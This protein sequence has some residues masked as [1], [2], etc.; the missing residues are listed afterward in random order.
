MT[1]SLIE[2]LTSIQV[3]VGTR[4]LVGISAA[5]EPQAV[6]GML[7]VIPFGA[8]PLLTS[9]TPKFDELLPSVVAAIHL[10][11]VIPF[12][13]VPLLTSITPLLAAIQPKTVRLPMP[14]KLLILPTS[15]DPLFHRME[16]RS[17]QPDS[18][19]LHVGRN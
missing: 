14:A 9:I 3:L 7:A 10:A 4:A 6:V 17:Q 8:V 15:A 11:F 13:A 12:G 1:A 2:L 16:H 18:F 5:V 19:E